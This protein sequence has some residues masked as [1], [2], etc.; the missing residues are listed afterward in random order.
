MASD[1]EEAPVARAV[2]ITL[3]ALA[4]YVL[5][6]GPLDRAIASG[7]RPPNWVITAYYPLDWTAEHCDPVA[8]VLGWYVHLWFPDGAP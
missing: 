4:L 1:S 8:K 6:V 3:A 2:L 7:F 5:S